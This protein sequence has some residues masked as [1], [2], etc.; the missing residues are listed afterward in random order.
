MDL[1][2]F[3][4][5]VKNERGDNRLIVDFDG[6]RYEVSHSANEPIDNQPGK[7]NIVLFAL[8]PEEQEQPQPADTDVPVERVK[9]KYT[10]KSK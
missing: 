9:R 1:N 2:K 6:E 5:T 3:L 7:R 10:R 8:I 4:P